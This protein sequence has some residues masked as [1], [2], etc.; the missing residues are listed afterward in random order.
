MAGRSPSRHLKRRPGG[1]LYVDT[2]KTG[3]SVATIPL[4]VTC[5]EALITH[6]R[7]Q[8]QERLAAGPLWVDAGFVFTT[9]TGTAIDGSNA[10]KGFYGLCEG[11]GIRRRR[12]R[13]LR[14]SA[15]TPMW[16]QGCRST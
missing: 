1:G 4:P 15:A 6:R 13:A 3:A 8:A 5:V 16:E 2:A 11:A 14:H 9:P 10:L 12:F 7:R